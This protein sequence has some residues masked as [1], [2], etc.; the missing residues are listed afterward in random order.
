MSDCC[1]RVRVG[2]SVAFVM[3]GGPI[4][5]IQADGASRRYTFEWS[6][7]WGPSRVHSV[8]GELLK[9]PFFPERSPFWPLFER[10]GKGGKKVDEY[11]RCILAL[12]PVMCSVCEGTGKGAK[13][14]RGHWMV[15]RNCGGDG[16]VE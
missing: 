6:E 1:K 11:N 9:N 12:A 10:W 4:Y 2:G 3:F 14:K 5:T 8:T 16:V 13:I 15:C 7:R